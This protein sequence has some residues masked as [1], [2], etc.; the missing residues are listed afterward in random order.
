[1]LFSNNR[2]LKSLESAVRHYGRLLDYPSDSVASC[3]LCVSALYTLYFYDD[4][5]MK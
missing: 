1:M 4:E 2:L 3:S 5:L